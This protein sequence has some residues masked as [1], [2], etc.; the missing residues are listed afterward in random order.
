MDDPRGQPPASDGIS[1]AAA[2]WNAGRRAFHRSPHGSARGPVCGMGVCHECRTTVDGQ[3]HV[4]TCGRSARPDTRIGDV[5]TAWYKLP[6]GGAQRRKPDAVT[7]FPSVAV[8]GAGP[9]GLT[10]AVHAAEAGASVLLLDENPRPGGQIWRC[11][12][13]TGA[14]PPAHD[15]HRR[16]HDAGVSTLVGARVVHAGPPTRLFALDADDRV[17]DIRAE[18]VVLATGARELLLPFP[19]WTLP[20]VMGAGGLQALAKNGLDVRDRRIVVA[21]SG[22]LLLAVAAALRERGGR[23]LAI[24]EQAPRRRVLGL[25]PRLLAHPSKLA[26]GLKLTHALR[27]VRRLYSSWI[28]SADGSSDD[29]ESLASIDVHTPG[30][31]ESIPCDLVAYGCGLVPQTE[32]AQ[33][34][35]CRLESGAIG[36]DQDQRTSVDHVF[37]AGEVCGVAGLDAALVE[38]AIAGLAAAGRTAAASG[39]RRRRD[40]ERRFA[41]TFLAAWTLDDRLRALPTDDTIVCRCEDVPFGAVRFHTDPR[42]AKLRTRCGM[43]PCQGRMCGPA[44]RW[45]LG[46]RL[47]TVRPPYSPVPLEALAT[48]GACVQ[49]R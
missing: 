18:D 43:G 17:H 44:L 25:G 24:V 29:G 15:M 4:R 27:G 21:G 40:R 28:V 13:A 1:L 19:G 49:A 47:D 30:G 22:P 42:D 38:G 6:R 48:I 32:V 39:L 14:P 16:A 7:H 2:E 11:D 26:R 8:L 3:P 41:R 10:A 12:H 33:S 46:W 37:A 5:A 34:L 45:I 20:G 23:I 36:V 9:A 35:G 31:S